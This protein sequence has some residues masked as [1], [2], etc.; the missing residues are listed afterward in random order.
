[1]YRHARP[2]TLGI[3]AGTVCLAGS[4][5]FSAIAQVGLPPNFAPHAN[6]GW[7][8]FSRRFIPPANGPGPVRPHPAYPH[9]SNDE[10][11]LTGRQPTI[12]MGDPDSPILQPWAREV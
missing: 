8:A 4:L 6:V 12:A 2:F 5:S 7:F 3:L 10:Y 1:M 9:V 11:R